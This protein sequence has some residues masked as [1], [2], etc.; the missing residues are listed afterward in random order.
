MFYGIYKVIF[1]FLSGN[2]VL[3][4]EIKRFFT[5]Y[6]YENSNQKKLKRSSTATFHKMLALL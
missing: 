2:E 5:Q 4:K 6:N 1:I 3:F